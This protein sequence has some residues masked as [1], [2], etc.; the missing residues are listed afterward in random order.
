VCLGGLP[1]IYKSFNPDKTYKIFLSVLF[2]IIR[3][4]PSLTLNQM[5]KK[6][7][8]FLSYIAWKQ[9]LV[10]WVG[11]IFAALFSAPLAGIILG[12]QFLTRT[13]FPI[14]IIAIVCGGVIAALSYLSTFQWSYRWHRLS[15]NQGYIR[16]RSTDGAFLSV[17]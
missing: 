1:L 15:T 14:I 6:P 13:V 2:A 11:A 9:R 17:P 5:L 12:S 4:L 7:S 8:S 16:Q 3:T 10:F